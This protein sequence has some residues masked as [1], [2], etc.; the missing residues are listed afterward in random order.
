MVRELVVVIRL[1][2]ITI[3]IGGGA[4]VLKKLMEVVGVGV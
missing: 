3:E 4:T 1:E 2:K